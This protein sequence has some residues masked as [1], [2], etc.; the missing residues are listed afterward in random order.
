MEFARK[1]FSKTSILK[2]STIYDINGKILSSSQTSYPWLTAIVKHNY[3]AMTW[4]DHGD[5]YSSGYD[6]GKIM[7]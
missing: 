7:A 4:Y 2:C 6:H 1:Y 5:S 3:H